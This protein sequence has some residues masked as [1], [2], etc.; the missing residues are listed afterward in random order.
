ME[1]FTDLF[2]DDLSGLEGLGDF[3]SFTSAGQGTLNLFCDLK[4]SMWMAIFMNQV[5]LT[6][7]MAIQTR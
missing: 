6:A 1:N 3:S 2:S 7:A 5:F 4:K